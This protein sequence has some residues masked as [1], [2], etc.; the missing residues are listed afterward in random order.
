M[1]NQKYKFQKRGKLSEVLSA[2]RILLTT[3]H[4]PFRNIPV[5]KK[6]PE[7]HWKED[8]AIS[9]LWW[10]VIWGILMCFPLHNVP[11][12]LLLFSKDS[13]LQW[14]NNLATLKT[15]LRKKCFPQRTMKVI[16][17]ES[18]EGLSNLTSEVRGYFSLAER[19]W[20]D[21]NTKR[22]KILEVKLKNF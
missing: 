15:S 7:Y 1:A 16:F 19:R 9:S 21:E 22:R 8:W 12:K 20:T 11:N 3:S 13:L 2:G 18:Q 17:Q 5:T 10:T 6:T 4:L 14:K